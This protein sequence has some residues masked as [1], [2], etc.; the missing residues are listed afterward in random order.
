MGVCDTLM[1]LTT[2]LQRPKYPKTCRYEDSAEPKGPGDDQL[3]SALK[4]VL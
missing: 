4:N 1:L 3:S 2:C